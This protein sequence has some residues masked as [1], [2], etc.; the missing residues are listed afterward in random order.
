MGVNKIIPIPELMPY[1]N[2]IPVQ[3]GGYMNI[4]PPSNGG[5]F[6][7]MMILAVIILAIPIILS[8]LMIYKVRKRA[9]EWQGILSSD[10]MREQLKK[11]NERASHYIGRFDEL[12]DLYLDEKRRQ[13][14]R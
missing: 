10:D 7:L 14:G 5:V 3:S 4:M 13:K 6:I 9:V 1:Y 12:L 2:P 11:S 8:L